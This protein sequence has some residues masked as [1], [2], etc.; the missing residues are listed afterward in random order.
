MIIKKK[1]KI[2]TQATRGTKLLIFYLMLI[3]IQSSISIISDIIVKSIF[4]LTLKKR[5]I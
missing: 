4:S 1:K 5:D 2:E 3:I